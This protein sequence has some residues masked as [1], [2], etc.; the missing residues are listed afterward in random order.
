[1]ASFKTPKAHQKIL[2]PECDLEMNHHAEKLVD[3]VTR[4]EAE[5]LDPALGG[6]VKDIYAC[7]ECGRQE[8]RTHE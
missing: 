8:A 4:A 3:P 1:M 5:R 7:P 2:C 6:V